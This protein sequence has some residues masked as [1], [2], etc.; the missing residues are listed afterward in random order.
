MPIF[1]I[2]I[3]C[4]QQAKYLSECIHSLSSQTFSDFEILLIDDGSPDNTRDVAQKLALNESRLKYLYKENGGLSSARNFGITNAKGEYLVFL[5]SDDSLNPDYLKASYAKLSDKAD[6]TISGYSFFNDSRSIYHTVLLNENLSF[7]DII[8]GNIC[9]AHSIAIKKSLLNKVGV[10]DETLKS[11]EDWDL[12]IRLYKAGANINIINQVLANYRMHEH[13]M[14]R[15]AFRM[16][17]ALKIVAERA[18]LKDNRLSD[19][20]ENNRDYPEMDLVKSIQNKLVF[21]L[22]VSVKQGLIQESVELFKSETTHYGLTWK[23]EDFSGMYSYLSFR[24][25]FKKEDL[26]YFLQNYPPHFKAFF[27]EI[28][29]S[30]AEKKIALRLIFQQVVKRL[31]VAKFGTFGNILN[32]LTKLTK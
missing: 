23:P 10:F 25:Y 28:G 16:Y 1:S 17:Q 26:T 31:N 27:S 29:L 7:K 18:F 13:S 14:S 12:W 6:M 2:I 20:F 30:T 4:Y 11:A 24:Y 15:N 9:P 22:G 21:C 8:L 32:A 5:D 19:E 3:P